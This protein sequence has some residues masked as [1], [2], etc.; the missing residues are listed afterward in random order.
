[1]TAA[2]L[3]DEEIHPTIA[4]VLALG[5]DDQGRGCLVLDRLDG[6]PLGPRAVQGLATWSVVQLLHQIGE[7]L[8]ALHDA[9]AA[10]ANLKPDNVIIRRDEETASAQVLDTGIL[11][12]GDVEQPA[13]LPGMAYLAPERL[14]TLTEQLGQAEP[15]PE[16]DVYSFAVLVAETL[17]GKPLFAGCEDADELLDAKETR[18][19]RLVGTTAAGGPVNFRRLDDVLR[20]AL[21]TEP[22]DRPTNWSE[23]LEALTPQR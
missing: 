14:R 16:E 9:G 21:S 10:H 22:S 2:R 6:E 3:V 17:G 12:R 1:P 5:E 13:G 15:R 23:F 8:S 4:R 11:I 19:Y 18:R 20:R 7:G